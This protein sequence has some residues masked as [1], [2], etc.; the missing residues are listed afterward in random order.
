MFHA[1]FSETLFKGR[2]LMDA[3]KAIHTRRSIRKFKQEPIPD[4]II[5]DILSAAMQAPSAGNQQPWEFII[6]TDKSVLAKIPGINPHA[7]MVQ[8]AGVSI[9]ICADLN[10]EKYPGFWVIDC[11]AACENLLLAAHA[12][13]LGGVWTG[14]YPIEERIAGFKKLFNLPQNIMPHS[15]IAIGYPSEEHKPQDRYKKERIHLNSW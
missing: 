6:I 4:D 13:G 12:L 9:L 2:R 10:R 3:I 11:S 15:L 14:V 7:S 5:K 1:L 8:K